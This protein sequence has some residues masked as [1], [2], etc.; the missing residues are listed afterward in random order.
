MFT[1]MYVHT[2][3]Y[4]YI[5]Y[6]GSRETAAGPARTGD[7]TFSICEMPRPPGIHNHMYNIYI[8]IYI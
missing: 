3:I 5:Y 8:Y 7:G 4:I 6:T 2:Y 1:H